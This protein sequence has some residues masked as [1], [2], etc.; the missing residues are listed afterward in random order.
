MFA[1]SLAEINFVIISIFIMH[2]QYDDQGTPEHPDDDDQYDDD[3]Y[4]DDHD[5]DDQYDGDHGECVSAKWRRDCPSTV[6]L[7]ALLTLLS[8]W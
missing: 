7:P 5:D 6:S 4:D 2:D 8:S 3:Q 1:L